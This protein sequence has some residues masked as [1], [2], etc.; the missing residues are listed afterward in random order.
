MSLSRFTS[1]HRKDSSTEMI[2]TKIAHRKSL[3]QKEN[4]YKEYE[5]NRH[6]GLK[7]VNVPLDGRAL[8]NIHETSQDLGP[9]TANTKPRSVKTVLSDQRK[10]MLQKYKEEKQL[11]KLKEQR[12]KAKREVFKVGLYRPEVPGFLYQ[13]TLKTEPKKVNL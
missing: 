10:Q 7:D 4:R 13:K 9:E 8:L 12:E 3:S 6:F 2:R 5:R 1:G 11:Q